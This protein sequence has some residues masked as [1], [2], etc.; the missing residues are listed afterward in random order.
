[1]P[2][3]T[4]LFLGIDVSR[5][6]LGLALLAGNGSVV[7]TLTRSYSS[8]PSDSVDPLDWWR[9]ARTGIKELLRRSKV[10]ASAI[11][12][13][14]VTG[15]SHGFAALDREGKPLC[16]S[17]I[18]PQAEAVP[19]VETLV[20]TVGARNLVNL[21]GETAHEGATAVK[22]LWLKESERRVWHDLALILPPKDFLRF[23]LT[24][25]IG[26]CAY[27][28][29][30]SLL[31]NPKN[32]AWSKLLLT[33]LGINPASLP[34]IQPGNSLAGRVTAEAAKESGLH[35]GT[36][37]ITGVPHVAAAAISLGASEPGTALV[38][39]GGDG[40]LL[41]PTTQAQRDASGILALQCHSLDDRWALVCDGLCSDSPILWLIHEVL[42]A[43]LAQARR[44]KREPLDLL[45]ELA[46]EVPTGAEGLIFHAPGR[47]P[48]SG[49]HGLGFHHR[50]GHLVRA[51]L[52]SGALDVR[53]ALDAAATLNQAPE[54]LLVTGPSATNHLWCQILADA[55]HRPV[56]AHPGESR[57]AIGAAM[58]ASVAVGTFKSVEEAAKKVLAKPTVFQPR[59]A[60]TEVYDALLPLFNAP[61]AT[62]LAVKA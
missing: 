44:A 36:P 10:T 12:C 43:D 42:L 39:L 25:T 24:G 7:G 53:R 51:M 19:F 17:V 48:D 62:E 61:A 34:P 52:E 23:R 29:T 45:A 22:L 14:G 49:F 32:R 6:T 8:A 38:E 40:S 56:H 47:R 15:D 41:I 55:T 30:A 21:T 58:L 50:R 13:I 9:A 20:K 59:K 11:R 46:A 27:D 57:D 28:A 18:G 37:V 31:G 54:R 5:D 60:A 3:P 26:T 1:M 35:P 16:P 33:Q 4:A 2:T